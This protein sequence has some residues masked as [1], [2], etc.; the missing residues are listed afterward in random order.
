MILSH[1]VKGLI[2]FDDYPTWG[3]VP[4]HLVTKFSSSLF[5]LV[6]GVC[7]AVAYMPHVGTARWSEKRKGLLIRGLTI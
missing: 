5:I 1:G 4:I 7:L 6:F 2:S 3:L